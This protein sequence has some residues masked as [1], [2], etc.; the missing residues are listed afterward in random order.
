MSTVQSWIFKYNLRSFLEML[1]WIASYSPSDGDLDVISAG[2]DGTNDEREKWF[3]YEFKGEKRKIEFQVADDPGSSVLHF[4][5]AAPPDAVELV[6]LAYF[7]ASKNQ[8][9]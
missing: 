5:I 8:P 4:R 7:V 1:G 9:L 2:V 3:S 6:N